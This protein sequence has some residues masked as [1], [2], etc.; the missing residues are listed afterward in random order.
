MLG[1]L[2]TAA[3]WGLFLAV[4]GFIGIGLMVLA[5]II[6]VGIGVA[7]EAPSG[8]IWGMALAYLIVAL[9]YFL[10]TINLQRFAQRVRRSISQSNSQ[11]LEQSMG[12]LAAFFKLVGIYTIL[13][14]AL[15]II[16]VVSM[17]AGAFDTLMPYF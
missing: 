16:V 14:I 13:I 12:N 9:I 15:Y 1:Y 11:L 4:L 3:G 8:P 17:V 5:A 2:K 7:G 10:P 6:M